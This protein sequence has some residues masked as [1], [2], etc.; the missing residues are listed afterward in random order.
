MNSWGLAP[1]HDAD[2]DHAMAGVIDAIGREHFAVSA[3]A[4][5]THVLGIGSWAVYRLWRDR[6]PVMHLSASHG[7]ADTT[8]ECFSIYR[9]RQLYRCDSSFEAVRREGRCGRAVML[10]MRADEA[11][12]AE[13]R[14]AI[15]RRHGMLERLSV[16]RA[17]DDGSLLAVNVY[18]HA[19]AHGATEHA[20][21]ERFGAIASTLIAAVGRH[22]EW[23]RMTAPASHRGALLARCPALTGRELDVLERLLRGMTYDGIAADTALSVSTVKTYRARAFERLD[24]HFKSELFALFVAPSVA[25]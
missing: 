24:I 21:A 13:H 16:A 17:E 20:M 8:G 23:H 14:D 6:P 19:Q 9:D 7:I 12:S 10:R 1:A 22:V 5:L 3:L 25:V 18:R 2:A 4:S 15:Y 11:P